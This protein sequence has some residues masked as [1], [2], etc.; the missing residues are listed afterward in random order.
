MDRGDNRALFGIKP[1]NLLTFLPVMQLLSTLVHQCETNTGIF[2]EQKLETVQP[3]SS[4]PFARFLTPGVRVSN[5]YVLQD[6]SLYGR[7][8]VSLAEIPSNSLKEDRVPDKT[9]Y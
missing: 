6:V 8:A 7:F 1:F 2:E 9:Q 3:I 5:C 4:H